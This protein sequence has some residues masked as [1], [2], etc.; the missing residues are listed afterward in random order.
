MICTFNPLVIYQ[1][2]ML[3][4]NLTDNATY[5]A[6]NAVPD[7]LKAICKSNNLE[8]IYLSSIWSLIHNITGTDISDP[9]NILADQL[10]EKYFRGAEMGNVR[11]YLAYLIR[12]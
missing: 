12:I 9:G 1:G 6:N 8:E 2:Y 10:T 11:D 5:L 7:I 3:P 4:N